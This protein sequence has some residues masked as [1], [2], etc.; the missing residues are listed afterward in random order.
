MKCS[1]DQHCRVR[2]EESIHFTA[3][4]SF[5]IKIRL[6]SHQHVSRDKALM[7][8]LLLYCKVI[9]SLKKKGFLKKICKM[10]HIKEN[11]VCLIKSISMV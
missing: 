7:R 11:N 4:E 1:K 5:D 2:T 9:K 3:S 10:V 8:L 6:Q